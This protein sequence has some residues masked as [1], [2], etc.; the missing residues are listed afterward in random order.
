MTAR[1]SKLFVSATLNGCP[2]FSF[3]V[4]RYSRNRT[5]QA[6]WLGNGRPCRSLA[7]IVGACGAWRTVDGDLSG[8]S[9]KLEWPCSSRLSLAS[10]DDAGLGCGL[11]ADTSGCC[12][13]DGSVAAQA[14]TAVS[15]MTM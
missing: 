5:T 10:D 1:R 2:R 12:D 13:G 3:L 7:S 15:P 9:D 4:A 8:A 14:S 6:Y 11:F